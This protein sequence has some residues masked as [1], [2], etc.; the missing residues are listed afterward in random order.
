MITNEKKVFWYLSRN[1]QT[2]IDMDIYID[3]YHLGVLRKIEK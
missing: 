2:L 3:I 1:L